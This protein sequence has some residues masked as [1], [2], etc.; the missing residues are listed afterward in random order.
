MDGAAAPPPIM[1]SRQPHEKTPP[2]QAPS[3]RALKPAAPASALPDVNQPGLNPVCPRCHVDLW[4]G[5]HATGIAWRCRKCGGESLNFSQFRRLIP[6]LH[7]NEIWMTA[8][9]QPVAPH[10]RACCPECR[11]EMAAVLVPFHGREIELD[12]CRSCQRLWMDSQ[13]NQTG[14]LNR[15]DTEPGG[16][17]PVI[18]MTGRG[19]ERLFG[20]QM[21]RMR[22]RAGQEWY[23]DATMRF[24]ILLL[25]AATWVVLKLWP[26]LR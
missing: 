20:Q 24:W 25:L 22:S 18:R 21:Q 2:L 5:R 11:R 4:G 9:E 15:G 16:K 6:E 7:A 1:S 14:R 17:P 8:M 10:R 3:P 23:H 12:I 19:I 13:E 26:G